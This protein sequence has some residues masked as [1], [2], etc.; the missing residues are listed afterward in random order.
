MTDIPPMNRRSLILGLIAAPAAAVV[1]PLLRGSNSPAAV[2]DGAEDIVRTCWVP[3][4]RNCVL[5][6]HLRLIYGRR[7]RD[8]GRERQ[9]RQADAAEGLE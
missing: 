5:D 3:L 9:Y 2:I 8:L 4:P 1:V 6:G 7:W